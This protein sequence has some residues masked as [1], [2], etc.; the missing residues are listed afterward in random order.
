MRNVFLY[1]MVL[2]VMLGQITLQARQREKDYNI[3]LEIAMFVQTKWTN[4]V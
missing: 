2:E 4:D 1:Y 3:Q